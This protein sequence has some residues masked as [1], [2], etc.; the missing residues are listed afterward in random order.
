MDPYA[1]S[2]PASGGGGAMIAIG[3]IVVLIIAACVYFFVL[4]PKKDAAPE[5]TTDTDAVATSNTASSNTAATSNTAA[6]SNTAAT[7]NTVTSNTATS[8]TYP[9]RIN[10]L[11]AY[12]QYNCPGASNVIGSGN[13]CQFSSN[14]AAQTYCNS[15]TGCVGYGNLRNNGSFQVVADD[16]SYTITNNGEWDWYPRTTDDVM[17]TAISLV[18]YGAGGTAASPTGYSLKNYMTKQGQTIGWAINIPAGSYNP[19]IDYSAGNIK[20]G[21][22]GKGDPGN[23]ANAYKMALD[24]INSYNNLTGSAAFTG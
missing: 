18:L 11:P 20:I 7:S 10:M 2:P 6:S 4:K 22:V 16:P 5:D 23:G 19:E 1:Q 21:G 3:F 17:K 8:Y 15:I 9:K 12:K 24:A 13:W 14:S